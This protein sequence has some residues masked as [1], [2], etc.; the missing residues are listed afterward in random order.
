MFSTDGTRIGMISS[1]GSA[2]VTPWRR[3]DLITEA[4]RRANRKKLDDAEIKQF[5]FEGAT[6]INYCDG[7]LGSIRGD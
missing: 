2:Y 1:D 5:F 4:C 6:P 7:K 3:E